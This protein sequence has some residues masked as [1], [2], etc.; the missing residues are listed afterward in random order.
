MLDAETTT[1]WVEI[2]VVFINR[3]GPLQFPFRLTAAKK[4]ISAKFLKRLLADADEDVR[5]IAEGGNTAEQF[6]E[7][8]NRMKLP[9]Q[10]RTAKEL[11]ALRS[12]AEGD[13][14]WLITQKIDDP[15]RRGVAADWLGDSDVITLSDYNHIPLDASIDFDSNGRVVL[16][17]PQVRSPD[18]FVALTI[19]EL[20]S[21]DCPIQVRECALA[22]CNRLF[23]RV[24]KRR[25]QPRLC[26]SGAH[27][28]KR[29][30]QTYKYGHAEKTEKRRHK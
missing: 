6:V 29:R 8:V 25:G 26:C 19:A 9:F 27:A 12:R 30:K 13:V 18:A 11:E 24:L 4:K 1:N 7:S 23:I 3:G 17:H 22:S 5:R 16:G 14:R 2:L 21:P 10:P 20:I 15:I 28:A